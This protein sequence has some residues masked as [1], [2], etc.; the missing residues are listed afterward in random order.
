MKSSCSPAPW[1]VEG[2]RV[3]PGVHTQP[4]AWT[5]VKEQKSCDPRRSS[6]KEGGARCAGEG[7][8]RGVGLSKKPVT[9]NPNPEYPNP[10]PEYPN[11]EFCSRILGSNLQNPNF[12]RV[13]RVSQSGTRNTRI[14]R[15]FTCHVVMSCLIFNLYIYNYV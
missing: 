6:A 3:F 11:P 15:T 2:V 14:T 7:K 10:N 1:A 12:F 4:A 8:E 5:S 9:W 13:I